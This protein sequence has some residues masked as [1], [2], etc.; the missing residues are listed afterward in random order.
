MRHRF[1]IALSCLPALL[2]PPL[3]AAP[4]MSGVN[5]GTMSQDMSQGNMGNMKGMPGM[6]GMQGMKGMKG[7]DDMGDSMGGMSMNGDAKNGRKIA[8]GVCAGCHGPNGVSASDD[9]P[10]L[11]GQNAMY[12]MSALQA[13]RNKTRNVQVMND[14]ASK[15]TGQ[16]IADVA[17]YYDS[18]APAE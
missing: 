8:Q 7:M 2:S 1:A 13:Y 4:P 14:V 3:H 10:D 17:A 6:D 12:I 16:D 5:G 11:A 15:L 9:Y 18:L